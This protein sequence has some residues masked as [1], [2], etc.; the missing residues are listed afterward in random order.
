[1]WDMRS[2]GRMVSFGRTAGD[3][4]VP[5]SF[6]GGGPGGNGGL[7]G[8]DG[9]RGGGGGFH[10]LTSGGI[11]FIGDGCGSLHRLEAIE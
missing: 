4:G 7:D 11:G 8:S 6:L 1:M 2:S 5:S 3:C 9:G 10:G